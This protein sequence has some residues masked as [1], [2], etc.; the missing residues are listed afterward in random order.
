MNFREGCR[1]VYVAHLKKCKITAI[2]CYLLYVNKIRDQSKITK[3]KPSTPADQPCVQRTYILTF[4]EVTVY[5]H[6]DNNKR[7]LPSFLPAK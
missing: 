2:G 1:I 7:Q 3:P 4:R 6:C 5:A